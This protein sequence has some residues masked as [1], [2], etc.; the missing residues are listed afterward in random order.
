M[1]EVVF[2][3]V[4]RRCVTRRGWAL[5]RAR[6]PGD[7]TASCR[8]S[9][10]FCTAGGLGQPHLLTIHTH[11]HQVQKVAGRCTLRPPPARDVF[12]RPACPCV[13]FVCAGNEGRPQAFAKGRA[14]REGN[15]RT[16]IQSSLR[17]VLQ[18]VAIL[19]LRV[20]LSA[21]CECTTWPRRAS[22]ATRLSPD[23][24]GSE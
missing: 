8:D 5:G 2:W 15:R 20:C 7:F 19:V 17:D 16:L 1:Q 24:R 9:C 14:R 22:I 12:S 10:V 3:R 18:N 6:D 23:V 13:R 11:V 21:A 4:A